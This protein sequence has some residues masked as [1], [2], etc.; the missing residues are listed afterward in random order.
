[1]LP[2]PPSA[3][4]VL[5]EP[6]RVTPGGGRVWAWEETSELDK[7][8]LELKTLPA[9]QRAGGKLVLATHN[10]RLTV[11]ELIGESSM[12]WSRSREGQAGCRG[13]LERRREGGRE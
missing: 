6:G 1:M 13:G 10:T 2:L 8:G 9:P 7:F 11:R 3:R 4:R 12:S 5:T